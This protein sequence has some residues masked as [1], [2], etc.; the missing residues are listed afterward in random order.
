[1]FYIVGVVIVML[2]VPDDTDQDDSRFIT[3]IV[4]WRQYEQ[5]QGETL[6]SIRSSRLHAGCPL[7]RNERIK[8]VEARQ[9]A[10]CHSIGL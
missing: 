1:M 2:K 4:L 3:G 8:R 5:R 6:I 10:G 9:S 7:S